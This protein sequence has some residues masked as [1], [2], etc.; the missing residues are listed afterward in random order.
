GRDELRIWNICILEFE[1]PGG[2]NIES[3]RLTRV[4]RF[5]ASRQTAQATAEPGQCHGMDLVF[6]AS[7]REDPKWGDILYICNLSGSGSAA[8]RK[9]LSP[10][11]PLGRNCCIGREIKK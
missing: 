2:H 11:Q 6:G 5:R 1:R 7:Q 8:S 3:G 10:L 9:G 4:T